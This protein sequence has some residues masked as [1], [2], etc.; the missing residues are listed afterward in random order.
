[1]PVRKDRP[2][3]SDTKDYPKDTWIQIGHQG[4]GNEDTCLRSKHDGYVPEHVQHTRDSVVKRGPDWPPRLLDTVCPA[5]REARDDVPEAH[6]ED[7][8]GARKQRLRQWSQPYE[9]SES[10]RDRADDRVT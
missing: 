6:G 3:P 8:L 5:S 9:R 1:M 4:I 2:L 7:A 10:L